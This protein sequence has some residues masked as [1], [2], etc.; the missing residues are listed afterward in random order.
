MGSRKEMSWQ[1][2]IGL[3]IHIELNTQSKLFTSSSTCFGAQPNSQANEI[4]L[5]LPGTLPRLNKEAL[6]KAIRLGLALN[7]HINNPTS[8]DR[9]HYFYPDLPKGYQITQFFYPIIKDGVLDIELEQGV[10]KP[11]H[12]VQAHLEENAGKSVHDKFV[13]YTALDFNRTGNPLIEVVSAPQLSSST[14]AVVYA[15]TMHRLVTWLDICNGDMS[16]G[17]F[18]ADVN[19]SVRREGE[20]L[21]TRCEIKNLNSFEF[22]RQAIDFETARQIDLLENGHV[23]AQETR[24]FDVTT[25]ETHAMRSKENA[26]DYRYFPDPD[27]LAVCV[28]DLFKEEKSKKIEPPQLV[29]KRFKEEYALD[30][31]RYVINREMAENIDA[32]KGNSLL[33]RWL[34]D[35]FY[36]RLENYQPYQKDRKYPLNL[37][38]LDYLMKKIAQGH[39]STALARQYLD[40]VFAKENVLTR[41]EFLRQ[42]QVREEII[43]IL[44]N[45]QYRL[46]DEADV[47][48][49]IAKEA[50]EKNEKAV[51]EFRSGKEKALNVML[52]YM[53][54]KTQGKA[55]AQKAAELIKRLIAN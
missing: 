54:K 13:Q 41:Q 18:R 14:E 19:V 17:D 53:M 29:K 6:R 7:A 38:E 40:E 33:S 32:I 12:I 51:N 11:I 3:E 39:L 2:V 20:A 30:D 43:S 16:Q 28:D 45:S 10:N 9:K 46:L 49:A 48:E 36:P 5:A 24:L 15:K 31:A 44:Q 27:L 21:G 8:F 1:V 42:D 47:L 23:I 22:I 26:D 52:G 25:G 35:E 4:D 34:I 55:N 37:G 50:I